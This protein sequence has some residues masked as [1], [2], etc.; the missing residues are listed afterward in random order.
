M[1]SHSEQRLNVS[2]FRDDL[3][4]VDLLGPS[5]ECSALSSP[6]HEDES[7]DTHLLACLLDGS[8][9]SS[10]RLLVFCISVSLLGHDLPPG[11][12]HEVGFC[13]SAFS[14]L[15]GAVPNLAEAPGLH[16]SGHSL[17]LSWLRRAGGLAR[18]FAFGGSWLRALHGFGLGGFRLLGFANGTTGGTLRNAFLCRSRLGGFTGN[19]LGGH[20]V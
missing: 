19:G 11:V 13:K 6:V 5:V 16:R 18:G 2:S 8:G 17:G 7:R 20:F 10:E 9:P 12:H 3:I 1:K 4:G 15:L 14:E